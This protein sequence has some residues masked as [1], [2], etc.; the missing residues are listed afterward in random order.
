MQLQVAASKEAIETSINDDNK[1]DYK[2]EHTDIILNE[3]KELKQ[4]I[5]ASQAEGKK[6]CSKSFS[7]RVK[8]RPYSYNSN[9]LSDK[10]RTKSDMRFWE[11]FVFKYKRDWF[12]YFRNQSLFR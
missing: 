11:L 9:I 5:S 3:I 1:D 2:N 8:K 7:G 10:K 4:Q 12:L 6:D